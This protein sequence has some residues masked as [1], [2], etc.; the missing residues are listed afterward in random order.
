M[1]VE[2]L[3]EASPG[4]KRPEPHPLHVVCETVRI[5]RSEGCSHHTIRRRYLRLLFSIN[6]AGRD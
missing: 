2:W 5:R 3:Q 1:S 6:R 4:G